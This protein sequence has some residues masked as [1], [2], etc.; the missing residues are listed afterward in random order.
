MTETNQEENN[1]E[2]PV[3]MNQNTYDLVKIILTVT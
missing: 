3:V 2:I 1:G